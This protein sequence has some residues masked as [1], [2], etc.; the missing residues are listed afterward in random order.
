MTSAS[1]NFG[2][3]ATA[4]I[5]L[6]LPVLAGPVFA[7][8]LNPRSPAFQHT[9]TIG[10]WAFWAIGLVAA[11]V[12]STVSLT[13][14]RIL[15]PSSLAVTGW[16]VLAAEERA[17]TAA[18]LALAITSLAA[19]VALSAFVGDRFVNGS[20]YG[21]ERRMPLR[22][23]AALLLGPLELTW[24]AVVGGICAGPL[25]LA[26]RIWIPGGVMLII[27]WAA[28]AIG[29]RALH[30]LSQRWLVFVPAG[31]VV[32]D[33]MVLTDALLVQRQRIVALEIV[34]PAALAPTTTGTDTDTGT[35]SGTDTDTDTDLTAG[36]LGPRLRVALTTPELIVPAASRLR[37]SEPIEPY[38]VSA[39]L[40]VPSRPGWALAEARSRRLIA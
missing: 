17:D 40:V 31:M 35:D 34:K 27:G 7:N 11:L 39:V 25:L 26:A 28:A 6:T 22:A 30:G 4:V 36:A 2:R 20:A 9:A 1:R 18:S 29:V 37:R 15:A 3:W 23:P 24:L 13:A 33:R 19:V 12:P 14:I 16:A 21:D 5:W 8:A 32:V 38:E 10:L